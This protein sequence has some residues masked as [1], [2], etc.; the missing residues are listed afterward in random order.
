MGYNQKQEIGRVQN[1]YAAFDRHN[2]IIVIAVVE[3]NS[4]IDKVL[5]NNLDTEFTRKL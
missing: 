2:V 5:Y 1:F 3:L 4:I